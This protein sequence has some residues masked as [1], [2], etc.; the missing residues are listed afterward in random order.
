[1]PGIDFLIVMGIC[2]VAVPAM[3]LIIAHLSGWRRLCRRYPAHEH[4]ELARTRHG[5]MAMTSSWMRYNNCIRYTTD[6]RFLHIRMM[7]PF[8]WLFH[9]PMSIPWER[10]E[11][12]ERAKRPARFAWTRIGVG[13]VSIW[14][15]GAV[16]ADEIELRAGGGL[17]AGA[18]FSESDSAEAV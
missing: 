13:G 11:L 9:P 4:T 15:P 8:G 17:P 10:V 3:F 6:E 12:P 18:D 1:M 2:L 16:V 5:S 7:I 14:L